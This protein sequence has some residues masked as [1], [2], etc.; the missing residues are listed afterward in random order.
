MIMNALIKAQFVIESG[1]LLLIAI[2]LIEKTLR[3]GESCRLFLVAFLTVCALYLTA[4]G[5][6]FYAPQSIF[7]WAEAVKIPLSLSVIPL[8]FLFVSAAVTAKQRPVKYIVYHIAVPSAF[9]ISMPV[10]IFAA[11]L[12]GNQFTSG[13]YL[14]VW[15]IVGHSFLLIQTMLYTMMFFL[16]F[17]VYSRRLQDYYDKVPASANVFRYLIISFSVFFLFTDGWLMSS[18]LP[19]Q[20]FHFIHSLLIFISAGITGWLGLKLEIYPGLAKNS[21]SVA[22]VQ[23]SVAEPEMI[24]LLDELKPDE[25]LQD[26]IFIEEEN[27]EAETVS[28]IEEKPK[29]KAGLG[30]K[31]FDDQ[32]KR[33][34][35]KRMLNHLITNEL[36]TDP[37]LTLKHLANDLGTNTRYLSMVINEYQGRNFN[38]MLNY[39]RVKKVMRLLVDNEAESYSYLGLAQK[40]GFHSKSVFIAAFKTQTGTTPSEFS[41]TMKKLI[42]S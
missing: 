29:R 12:N 16:K 3:K 7:A 9:L 23:Q 10:V 35:Y 30:R 38:Q 17:R 5:L 14:T 15:S 21:L 36:Y 31:P 25:I 27:I 2:L 39:Y 37:K 40:A 20:G 11:Y 22:P 18:I 1:I 6:C 19:E 26:D 4:T 41:G 13:N 42:K 33:A 34:L 32:Q 28:E 24:E 8:F